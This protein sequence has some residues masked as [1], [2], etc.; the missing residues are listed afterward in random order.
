VRRSR[1]RRDDPSGVAGFAD[2]VV[3]ISVS[4]AVGY[5]I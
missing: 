3:V 1:R 4:S 2:V 5:L